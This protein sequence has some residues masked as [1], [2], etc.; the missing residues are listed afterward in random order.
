MSKDNKRVREIV[1][2]T[3]GKIEKQPDAWFS[4]AE[5]YHHAT[6]LLSTAKTD[7]IHRPYYFVA[8]LSLEVLLKAIAVKRGLI[9]LRTHKLVRLCE[10]CRI[11]I[12]SDQKLT[13]EFLTESIFWLGRYPVPNKDE[14]WDNYHDQV[15]EKSIRRS[16]KGKLGSA[17]AN[18][19]TF[20]TAENYSALW[21]YLRSFY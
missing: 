11:E 19:D 16:Y 21:E 4:Y 6:M 10:E 1:G 20:P 3:R 2:L 13:L 8:G 9:P 14:E 5:E 17:I 18:R 15:L 12:S 7:G